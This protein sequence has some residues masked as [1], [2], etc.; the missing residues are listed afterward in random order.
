MA[1]C[2]R[3]QLRSL[4]VAYIHPTY[5]HPRSVASCVAPRRVES[6]RAAPREN[7]WHGRRAPRVSFAS[8][9]PAARTT[10]TRISERE[11]KSC[12]RAESRIRDIRRG[13]VQMCSWQFDVENIARAKLL[14]EDLQRE[15][16]EI[17][18]III[19]CINAYNRRNN[20]YFRDI[21]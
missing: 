13:G 1:A 11:R 5:D 8:Y 17:F 10:L 21:S 4:R 14:V 18:I 19:I 12:A 6:R 15:C 7:R 3:A 2:S 9:I 16:R 20:T